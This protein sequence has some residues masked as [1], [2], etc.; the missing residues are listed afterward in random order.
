MSIFKSYDIRGIYNEEWNRDTA[1]RIGNILCQILNANKILVGMD[2]RVSSPEIFKAFSD[3]ATDYGTD[4]YYAGLTTTPMIYFGTSYFDFP[5]SVMITASHN[6]KN[7][8]GLKVSAKNSI[9]IGYE[10]GLNRIEEAINKGTIP[11]VKK[12]NKGKVIEFNFID[13]Y[14]RF[15]ENYRP[16]NLNL[17]YTVDFS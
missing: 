17:A 14:T 10:T 3:G 11:P 7:Y 4:T 2:G 16:E 8:N 15:M 12:E 13:K 1:Y 9:P 5:A 6:P